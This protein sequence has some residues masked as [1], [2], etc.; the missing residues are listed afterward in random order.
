[1]SL[2]FIESKEASLVLQRRRRANSNRLE[3]VIPGNLERECIE[4]KCSFEE[5]REVFENTEK[6]VSIAEANWQHLVPPP[7]WSFTSLLGERQGENLQGPSTASIV[8]YS[9]LLVHQGRR[10]HLLKAG[11]FHPTPCPSPPTPRAPTPPAHFPPQA[12]GQ[13]PGRIITASSQ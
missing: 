4:E 10:A 1:H 11:V 2:V 8:F 13:V 6:T 5:A 3:E 7:S 9:R 12:R